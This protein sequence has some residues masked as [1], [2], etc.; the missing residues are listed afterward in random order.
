VFSAAAAQ[1]PLGPLWIRIWDL[2]ASSAKLAARFAK[3]KHPQFQ[4]G[5]WNREIS[6]MR[7]KAE[8]YPE[9]VSPTLA[10]GCP[11]FS[12]GPP[13]S[14]FRPLCPN[15]PLAPAKFPDNVAGSH[16]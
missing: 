2:I 10:P 1:L 11:T 7:P 15:F 14:A 6:D 8:V 16:L 3:G 4:I 5:D 12:L 13:I 9:T